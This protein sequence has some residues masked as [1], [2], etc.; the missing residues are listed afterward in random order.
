[1]LDALLKALQAMQDGALIVTVT[2]GG[3]AE[4]YEFPVVG[5]EGVIGLLWGQLQYD[6][7]E[8]AHEKSC[9]CK[10]IGPI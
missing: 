4:R 9:I 3:I 10:F 6:Y 5:P 7:H 2:L 1:M 8:G